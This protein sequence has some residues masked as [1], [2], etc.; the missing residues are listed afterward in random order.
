MGFCAECYLPGLKRPIPLPR[1]N[2]PLHYGYGIDPLALVTLDGRF[3][4]MQRSDINTPGSPDVLH[5]NIK[6]Y[7]SKN[8]SITCRTLALRR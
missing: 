8:T 2:T 3:F 5:C 7:K 4:W 6:R 1:Y